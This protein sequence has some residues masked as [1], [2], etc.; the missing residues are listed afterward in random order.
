M[1]SVRFRNLVLRVRVLQGGQRIRR[2]LAQPPVV[3]LT[4]ATTPA[5]GSRSNAARVAC[6]A[7]SVTNVRPEPSCSYSASHSTSPSGWRAWTG[8]RWTADVQD[9]RLPTVTVKPRAVSRGDAAEVLGSGLGREHRGEQLHAVA[10]VGQVKG[11]PAP[12]GGQAIQGEALPAVRR[13]QDGGVFFLLKGDLRLVVAVVMVDGQT[14]VV[15]DR[16]AHDG[17]L[18]GLG[19]LA[20]AGRTLLGGGPAVG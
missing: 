18:A 17:F 8:R 20:L 12:T 4:Y 3:G 11:A 14:D 19:D 9:V 13:T 6:P 16:H 1:A 2:P 7:F 5:P 10:A 15:Q